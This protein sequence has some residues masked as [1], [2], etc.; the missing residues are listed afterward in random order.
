MSRVRIIIVSLIIGCSLTFGLISPAFA[1]NNIHRY[2]EDVAMLEA[3]YGYYE[4]WSFAEKMQLYQAMVNHSLTDQRQQ[5]TEDEIDAIVLE[6][7]G[8]DGRLD[9]VTLVNI[10]TVEKG[11]FERWSAEDKAWY[12]SLQLRLGTLGDEYIYLLPDEKVISPEK[13]VKI[14]CQQAISEYSLTTNEL[15]S[16][17][18]ICW[19]Y[20]V[21][22][23][24]YETK[25]P[26]YQIDFFSKNNNPRISYRIS[27]QG[28]F[29]SDIDSEPQSTFRDEQAIAM[30]QAYIQ[31][32][33][34]IAEN[35]TF[36]AWPLTGKQYFSD[37]IAPIVLANA[38]GREDAY[39]PIEMLAAAQFRYGLPD[40]KA[41]AQQEALD[42]A[43]ESIQQA[44]NLTE[45]ETR[46]YS[47]VA[48]FY[49]ITDEQNP[50]WKFTFYFNP[51]AAHEIPAIDYRLVHKAILHAYSGQIITCEQYSKKENDGSVA[52]AMKKY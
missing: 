12:S 43:K 38:S 31:S 48:V 27:G 37:Y 51:E 4:T 45:D 36:S 44:F 17:Y 15:T 1:D 14:A 23:E 29:I 9:V 52:F 30:E 3:S 13:A 10:M 20:L 47:S 41:I 49:D 19:C 8:V 28:F 22:A 24:D 32:H 16:S 26:D 39:E 34:D 6:R 5:I 25:A 46:A 21:Y 33:P 11:A 50:L 40:E 18:D 2:L 35:M 42:I 7:Y